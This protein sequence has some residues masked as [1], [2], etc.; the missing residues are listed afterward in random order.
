MYGHILRAFNWWVIDALVIIYNETVLVV[1]IVLFYNMVLSHALIWMIQEISSRESSNMWTF[2]VF[3]N[4]MGTYRR[5]IFNFLSSI[6]RKRQLH[7]AMI[8]RPTLVNAKWNQIHWF[9]ICLAK[10]GSKWNPSSLLSDV[11]YPWTTWSS[12]SQLKI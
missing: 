7:L 4:H 1:I 2:L 11:E 9:S 6:R 3:P 10:G 8:R 12:C 5:W